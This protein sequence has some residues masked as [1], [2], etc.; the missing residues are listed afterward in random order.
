MTNL[1]GLQIYVSVFIP[2]EG[3]MEC[4]Q[5]VCDFVALSIY[6]VTIELYAKLTAS[7]FSQRFWRQAFAEK[8]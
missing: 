8:Q 5:N 1:E 3:D 7:V 4:L 6:F 2:E